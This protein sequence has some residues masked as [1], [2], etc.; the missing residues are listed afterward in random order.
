[1][2]V[3]IGQAEI[4]E[5]IDTFLPSLMG[6][7]ITGLQLI[8]H[9]MSAYYVYVDRYN[10]SLEDDWIKWHEEEKFTKLINSYLPDQLRL[11]QNRVY[12][13]LVERSLTP[14]AG[15]IVFRNNRT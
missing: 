10:L 6:Q 5:L 3:R 14:R 11:E 8:G 12:P 1:M 2:R 7:K 4:E 15:V 13:L 9:I